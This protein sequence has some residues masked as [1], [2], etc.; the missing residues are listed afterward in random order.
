MIKYTLLFTF[1]LFAFSVKAQEEEQT[2][3]LPNGFGANQFR[4]NENLSSG[5]LNI[6]LPI[7]NILL[8][9]SVGY[10]T[11]GIRVNKRP[12]IV[13]LGWN[14]NA[15]GYIV[16]DKRGLADDHQEGYSGKN[17]RGSAVSTNPAEANFHRLVTKKTDATKTDP[18][19]DIYHFQ[20]LGQ[21]GSFTID[22][23]R[24]V[25]KLSAN[26]L[27]IKAVYN[28]SNNKYDSFKITDGQGN[29]YFF[30]MK[31]TVR[32]FL[33]NQQIELFTY[34]W[35]LTKVTYYASGEDITFNYTNAPLYKES[36]P[37]RWRQWE[38]GT[39]KTHEIGNKT[40]EIR[41]IEIKLLSSVTFQNKKV[42][43]SYG[44]RTDIS[45][46][47]KLDRISYKVND[48]ERI[49][50]N[51]LYKYLGTGSAKRLMLAGVN[52]SDLSA[53]LFQF[54]YYGEASSEPK[55]PA[56]N[57]FKQDHWGFFNANTSS[58]LYKNL[59]ADR[60]PN[61]AATRANALKRVYDL[62]GG[63]E[64]Y[65]YQL[66]EYRSNNKDQAAGGLR[67][68][69]VRK[70]DGGSVNYQMRTYQYDQ[71]G[72]SNSS[73]EL[74]AEPDYD[75]KFD[76]RDLGKTWEKHRE[77]SLKNLVD[78]QGRHLIYEYVTVT[79]ADGGQTQFKFKTFAYE[80][81]QLG[82]GSTPTRFT[83]GWNIRKKKYE[84]VNIVDLTS[85]DGPFG[86]NHFKGV[87]AGLPE[88][89]L[90]KDAKGNLLTKEHYT[91][92]ARKNAT[93]VKGLNSLQQGYRKYNSGFLNLLQNEI[94]E[95]LLSVYELSYGYMLNTKIEQ[96]TYDV[97][98]KA[99]YKTVVTN[100][101]YDSSHPLPNKQETYLSGNT[102][103]KRAVQTDYLFRE[104]SPP[105]D[106]A[107]Y[108]LLS[109]VKETRSYAD[110]KFFTKNVK[111]Y[112]NT[113]RGRLAVS[114][115]QHYSKQKQVKHTGY[116]YNNKGYLIEQQDKLSG[117]YST[118]VYDD[119]GRI[120]AEASN[121][122]NTK[123]AYTSFERNDPGGWTIPVTLRGTAQC[124]VAYKKCR[125]NCM[126]SHINDPGNLQK[127]IRSC[128]STKT[129]CENQ[130]TLAAGHLDR[131][132]YLLA[133]GNVTKALSA[134]TY[135]LFFWKKSGTVSFS[136]AGSTTKLKTRTLDGWT[137]EVW[138]VV[139]S[140]A[141][142][143]SL[144][145][146]ATIDHLGISPSDAPMQTYAYHPL[147]GKL[148]EM[149][150]N[151]H[152]ILYEFDRVGRQ[153]TMK[154]DNKDVI[155]HTTYHIA[156]YLDVSQTTYAAGYRQSDKS[157]FVTSNKDWHV[158]DNADW[159]TVTRQNSQS[160]D[161][162]VVRCQQ[163]TTRSSRTGTITLSGS[164]LTTQ[165]ISV[166]QEALPADYLR[167]SPMLVDLSGTYS[168]NVTI[169][170]S[171][172]VSWR[173]TVIQGSRNIS[174]FG[175]SGTGYGNFSV[176]P[177]SRQTN[178]NGMT[179]TGIVR[180]TGGGIN[181][182]IRVTYNSSNQF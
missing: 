80:R 71:P 82:S 140:A 132:A 169:N 36:T 16:R 163:N 42:E 93:K 168:T 147:F 90:V 173:A 172:N 139:M 21:G 141:G 31:E 171:S 119:N 5:V 33:D 4:T 122:R 30:T 70:K 178:S 136:G 176:Y 105:A 28:T 20:F 45:S 74:Y 38:Y 39:S 142:T 23:N 149:D 182:Y 137:F 88:E 107:T 154:D 158:T 25:V 121:A 167:V 69:K 101:S 85:F 162:L 131:Y 108:N 29:Q 130:A 68:Y 52:K 84:G 177:A 155:A 63:I 40:I 34:K 13:G 46:R 6:T 114:A 41:Y 83:K 174:I 97:K 115:E 127:C 50:Y 58:T 18:E 118:T 91:Y 111:T 47:R 8:P 27:L 15:G 56:Y 12:G 32:E 2:S 157:I 120:I 124:A 138:K 153:T 55:L 11:T 81:A 126:I 128:W 62:N 67:I 9:V 106:V 129:S 144:S 150:A 164:G 148:A 112:S 94:K 37:Y 92:T 53:Y 19:P 64:E 146:T 61:L 161:E 166:T 99:N 175:G 125:E 165:T 57:S 100:I 151:H 145:G 26:N 135:H 98:N 60:S 51:F 96:T 134:G 159:M 22:H 117:F 14:L 86:S 73:G 89:K 76:N 48:V 1:I 7:E 123:V 35:H 109:F 3:R 24:N 180:V 152:L 95:Y 79:D 102:S 160:V 103:S 77:F 49:S 17:K 87:A 104:S 78:E 54:T 181:R 44:S 143:L 75:F 65:E 156:G 43:F 170:V 179:S 72:T 116:A 133:K 113:P 66:N 10:T 110:T 59:G